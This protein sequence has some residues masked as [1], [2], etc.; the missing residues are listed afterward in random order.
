MPFLLVDLRARPPRD[1]RWYPLRNQPAREGERPC[2]RGPGRDPQPH[3]SSRR[4]E[5]MA[6]TGRSRDIRGDV[7]GQIRE[8]LSTRRAK[9]SPEQA[10]LPVY[11]GDRRRVAGLRRE[12]V[13]SLAGISS[14]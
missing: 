6:G 8:F 12:E 5:D 4:V 14:E 9:V 10:G 1:Q 13:A 7:R 2:E 11:R 3:R